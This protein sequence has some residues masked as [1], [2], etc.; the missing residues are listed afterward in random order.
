MEENKKQEGK[1]I[2]SNFK[3]D[4][5]HTSKDKKAKDFLI[6]FFGIIILLFLYSIVISFAPLLFYFASMV[7]VI[8]FIPIAAIVAAPVIFFKRGR[9]FIAVGI[10]SA[11]LIPFLV[12]GSCLLLLK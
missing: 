6:G 11:L 12:F 10:V 4:D 1:N 9:R 2:H 3:K 5:Y 7:W 8:Y